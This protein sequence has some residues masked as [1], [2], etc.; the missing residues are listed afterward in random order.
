MPKKPIT[1]VKPPDAGDISSKDKIQMLETGKNAS[2]VFDM[3]ERG[4]LDLEQLKRLWFIACPD[5]VLYAKELKLLMEYTKGKDILVYPNGPGSTPEERT[6]F[7]PQDDPHYLKR[8]YIKAPIY[9]K[10]TLTSMGEF[11]RIG[12]MQVLK[13]SRSRPF[14][15]YHPNILLYKAR[16]PEKV[17]VTIITGRWGS[18]KTNT[19]MR[20]N[21]MADKQGFHTFSNVGIRPTCK[22]LKNHIYSPSMRSLLTNTCTL[23]NQYKRRKSCWLTFDEGKINWDRVRTIMKDYQA[24]ELISAIFRKLNVN[25]C[26]IAQR[27]DTVPGSLADVCDVE[28]IKDDWKTGEIY[29]DDFGIADRFY[30]LDETDVDYIT[31]HI[32]T[33]NALDANL[34]LLLDKLN[35]QPQHI[36]QYEFIIKFLERDKSGLI[37]TPE[38]RDVCIAV[39]SGYMLEDEERKQRAIPIRKQ[40][41]L[42]GVSLPTIIKARKKYGLSAELEIGGR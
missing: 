37:W 30:D 29:I 14:W 19:G 34:G 4:T 18:G 13:P 9:L 7:T 3:L 42:T 8:L 22:V 24:L 10:E 31:E 32:S 38:I 33:F 5:D 25:I 39:M 41:M 6:V 28:I 23:M 16:Q 1:R 21:Q 26:Y 40:Q 17:Q 11:S 12:G 15:G 27:P 20:F 35:K 36:N 2:L